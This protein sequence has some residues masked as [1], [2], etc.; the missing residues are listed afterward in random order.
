[1]SVNAGDFA[2]FEFLLERESKTWDLRYYQFGHKFGTTLE[3]YIICIVYRSTPKEAHIIGLYKKDNSNVVFVNKDDSTTNSRLYRAIITDFCKKYKED[4]NAIDKQIIPADQVQSTTSAVQVLQNNV[5]N[6]LRE[7]DDWEK[8]RQ[9]ANDSG[10]RGGAFADTHIYSKFTTKDREEVH[11][12]ETKQVGTLQDKIKNCPVLDFWREC[13]CNNNS[14]ALTRILNLVKEAKNL[15]ASESTKLETA[16]VKYMGISNSKYGKLALKVHPDKNSGCDDLATYTMG[17]LA[18]IREEMIKKKEKK[19]RECEEK[20]HGLY[21]II[22]S[23]SES[24]F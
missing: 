24:L 21:I 2:A 22:N 11:E 8:A 6:M 10:L 18:Q 13:V 16:I 23:R 12:S 19:K 15:S 20:H 17:V 3:Q 7:N 9:Y 14:D 1:M 4:K 5:R